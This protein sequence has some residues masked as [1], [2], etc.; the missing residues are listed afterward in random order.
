MFGRRAWAGLST[1]VLLGAGLALGPVGPAAAE[2]GACGNNASKPGEII[3][4]IPWHLNWI[5]P[6]RIWPFATGKGQTVAVVDSGV[7]GNHPQLAGGH[8]LPGWDL[9][10]DRAD[11]NVD[12]ISHGTGVA[13]LIAAQHSDDVGF[14]GIAPDA[15]ILPV[16]VSDTDPAQDPNG[17]HQPSAAVIAGAVDWA[18]EHGATVIDVSQSLQ[19]DDKHLHAAVQRALDHGIVVVAAAGDQH[20][21][22]YQTDPPSYPAAYQGVIGVG[23][24]DESFVRAETSQVGEYVTVTAPGDGLTSAT[25]MYGYQNWSGTSFAAG[26]VAGTVALVRE[27][28]P[29]LTPEQIRARMIGTADPTPGGQRGMAYGHGI[30]DPYRAVTERMTGGSGAALPG[31]AKPSPNPAATA[32]AQWWHWTSGLSVLLAGALGVL[33]ILLVA[34]AIILPRGRLRRWRATRAPHTPREPENP[35]DNADDEQ[36]FVVPRPHGGG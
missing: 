3:K 5:D 20:N 6:D 25:R 10:R 12:C 9:M 17:P 2:D 1:A 8:V 16:R 31:M 15:K 11:D 23:A 34:G 33:L 32:R 30:V 24:V 29:S 7:D 14:H 36:L 18:R 21:P 28:R 19:V 22:K 13:S 26:L 35:A 4:E 27:A